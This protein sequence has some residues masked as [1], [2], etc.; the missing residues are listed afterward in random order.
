MGE[1]DAPEEEE[2]NRRSGSDQVDQFGSTASQVR[3]YT[4][5]VGVS[6]VR[7]LGRRRHVLDLFTAHSL[8]DRTVLRTY[9]LLGLGLL[10]GSRHVESTSR[11]GR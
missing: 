10:H 3:R 2:T 4:L 1:F 9:F 6:V 5:C 8:F 11:M 7:E